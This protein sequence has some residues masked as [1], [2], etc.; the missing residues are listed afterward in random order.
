MQRLTELF[1][2]DRYGGTMAT[3]RLSASANSPVPMLP[4]A[5]KRPVN[6]LT[7]MKSWVIDEVAPIVRNGVQVTHVIVFRHTFHR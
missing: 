7:E 1:E 3:R 2:A 6:S 5:A 4:Q